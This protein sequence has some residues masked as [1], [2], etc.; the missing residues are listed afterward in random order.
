MKVGIEQTWEVKVASVLWKRS[1][2]VA[3][4]R[5][6]AQGVHPEQPYGPLH[7][8]GDELPIVKQEKQVSFAGEFMQLVRGRTLP[9][10]YLFCLWPWTTLSCSSL[11]T[12]CTQIG[13]NHIPHVG[14][15][16]Y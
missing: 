8:E 4:P 14:R 7:L 1:S 11:L 6:R 3:E 15:V 5:S 16:Y 2:L 10:P 9:W 13:S 12:L